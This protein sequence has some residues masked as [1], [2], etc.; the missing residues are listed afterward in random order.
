MQIIPESRLA[1]VADMRGA[2]G[3]QQ[4]RLL[5]PTDDVHEADAI[6]GTDPHQ[7]LAEA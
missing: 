7:H 3:A 1:G 2:K 4:V 6:F 5:A